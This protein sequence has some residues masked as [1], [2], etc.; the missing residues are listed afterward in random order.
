MASVVQGVI[1][2]HSHL[3]S[4]HALTAVYYLVCSQALICS[5]VNKML[6]R[7]KVQRNGFELFFFFFFEWEKRNKVALMHPNEAPVGATLFV[8]ERLE[9]EEF[10]T[11]K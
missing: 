11:Q 8:F 1:I 3:F 4:P 9:L 7:H 2:S 5:L 6:M 10:V